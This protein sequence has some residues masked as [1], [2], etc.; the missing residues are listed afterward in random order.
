MV[1][2]TVEGQTTTISADQPLVHTFSVAGNIPIQVSHSRDGNLTTATA[3]IQVISAPVME[4][5][6]CVVGFY[7]EVK[8]PAL[9][10]GV[11][12]QLD[13]RI[14]IQ[15]ATTVASTEN[16][17]R[18]LRLNTLE[19]RSAVFRLGGTLGPILH[20]L[21]FKATR[22]RSGSETA[23]YF[24]SDLDNN[25]WEVVMPIV[26]DGNYPETTLSLEIFIGGVVF[27]DGLRTRVLLPGSY[28]VPQWSELIHF[29]KAGNVGS[30]CH[31]TS[32]SQGNI[33]IAYFQ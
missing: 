1:S 23:N 7:R 3:T 12:L 28:P 25:T 11:N 13:Q 17:D 30:N 6:V 18:I 31:R 21:F 10:T 14:D 32:I 4:N 29:Y 33:R 24:A 20:A 26:V 27:D 15:S 22:I 19:E 8:I 5:P 9:P 16:Q 2:I